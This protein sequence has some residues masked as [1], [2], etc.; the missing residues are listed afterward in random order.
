[1]HSER[2]K[3]HK[4]SIQGVYLIE[5]TPFVDDRGMFRRHFCADEFARHGI[6]ATMA[7]GNI[8]ENLHARTLRGFHY[9][10]PPHAEGKTFS[11][12]RGRIHYVVVDLRPESPT[13]MKWLPF[14]LNDSNR[15]SVHVPPQCANAFLTLVDGVIGHYYHSSAYVASGE[16][17][18]RFDDPAF[19]FIWP[20]R[21]EHIS[22]K[23]RSYPDFVVPRR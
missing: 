15:L 2:M 13:F 20:E 3:F 21:P 8:S 23:D 1:M 22:E 6:A 10:M 5:P 4:Q 14:D 7:Q 19:S 11:C 16:R 12:L 18:I 9:L 17:G